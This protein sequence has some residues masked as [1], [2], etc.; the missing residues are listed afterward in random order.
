MILEARNSFYE[1]CTVSIS[2]ATNPWLLDLQEL[3]SAHVPEL[4]K[5]VEILRMYYCKGTGNG[6]LLGS[7]RDVTYHLY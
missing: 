7:I 3:A 2:F 4:S 6:S 5:R 1:T